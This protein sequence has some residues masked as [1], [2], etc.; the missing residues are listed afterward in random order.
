VVRALTELRAKHAS[1]KDIPWGVNG[2]TG[3][4]V[5]MTQYGVSSQG[6]DRFSPSE[7]L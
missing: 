6:I 2:Q 5:D 1:G 4:I 3:D 7:T